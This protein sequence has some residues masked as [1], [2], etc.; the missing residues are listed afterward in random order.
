MQGR[1]KSLPLQVQFRALLAVVVPL[2]CIAAF[3][4]WQRSLDGFVWISISAFYA[5]L[6]GLLWFVQ[7]Q[8]IRPVR[9]ISLYAQ[10]VSASDLADLRSADLHFTHGDQAAGNELQSITVALKRL[11]RSLKVQRGSR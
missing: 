4:L 3:M 10:Q 1:F 5:S 11:L 8:L 7:V 6:A 9:Q 2:G